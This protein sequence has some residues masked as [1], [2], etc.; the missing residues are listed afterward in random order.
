MYVEPS[1]VGE[2]AAFPMYDAGN[3]PYVLIANDITRPP[4]GAS[5]SGTLYPGQN[6]GHAEGHPATEASA[7]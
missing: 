4:L 1:R 7:G 2:F 5:E 6:C 3:G